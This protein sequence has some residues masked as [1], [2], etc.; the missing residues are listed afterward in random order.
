MIMLVSSVLNITQLISMGIDMQDDKNTH[1]S[2]CET[3][4]DTQSC[5]TLCNPMN[6]VACQAPLSMGFPQA[7]ILEWVAISFFRGSS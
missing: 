5:L 3:V 1:A 7:K 4:K 2:K 6:C